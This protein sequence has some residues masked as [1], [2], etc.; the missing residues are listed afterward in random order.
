MYKIAT[1]GGLAALILSVPLAMILPPSIAFENGLIENFQVILLLGT[2][3][4]SLRLMLSTRDQGSK[5][6]HIFCALLFIL[7]AVRE[8]SWGRVFYPVDFNEK[9]PTFVAMTDYAWKL[10]AHVFIVLIGLAM[11]ILLVRRV[12]IRRLSSAPFPIAIFAVI[13]IGLIL[14]YGGEHGYLLGKLNGQTLEELNETLIY[15][16]QPVLCLYYNDQLKRL[17]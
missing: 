1:V 3:I 2:S 5:A 15:C 8:L 13:L 10:E 14:Q 11:L 17:Q 16:L 12:P 9:G 6:F 7:L 4:F